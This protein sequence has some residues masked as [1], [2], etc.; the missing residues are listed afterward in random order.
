MNII[1][2]IETCS[3]CPTQYEGLTDNGKIVYI[4]YRWGCLTVGVGETL[5][6]ALVNTILYKH[7]G[8]EFDGFIS[9]EN[10]KKELNKHSIYII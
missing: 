9:L 3:A 2:L 5:K 10:L 8:D 4:R 1:K 7:I 6:E